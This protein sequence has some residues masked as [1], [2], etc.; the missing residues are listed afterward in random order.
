MPPPPPVEAPSTMPSLV[1]RSTAA[2]VSPL[3]QLS[4]NGIILDERPGP[5][6]QV[7]HPATCTATVSRRVS[8]ADTA[9][10][11][12]QLSPDRRGLF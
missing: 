1:Q 3:D 11:L 10:Q 2:A 5:P 7:Q 9:S 4:D 12:N 6:A 8:V